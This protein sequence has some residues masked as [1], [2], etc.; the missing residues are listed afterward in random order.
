MRQVMGIMYDTYSAIV[1]SDRIADSA[2]EEPMLISERRTTMMDT[3]VMDL[4][5]TL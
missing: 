2:V 3:S 4:V 1:L 5:G